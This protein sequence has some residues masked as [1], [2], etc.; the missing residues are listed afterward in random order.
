MLT[1]IVYQKGTMSKDPKM[2]PII[3]SENSEIKKI[4]KLR[5]LIFLIKIKKIK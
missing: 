1:T 3:E 2:P 4:K 5:N